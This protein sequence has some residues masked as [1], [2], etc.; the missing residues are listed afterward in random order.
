MPDF[1]I[2]AATDADRS[3]IAAIHA[4]S[5]QEQY[6]DVLPSDFLDRE[7]EGAME[8][9]WQDQ[10]FGEGD[11]V[12]M[13]EREGE[14]I[15]FAATWCGDCAYID[16]LHVRSGQRSGGVGRALLAET[17]RRLMTQGHSAADL[18]VVTSNDRA[19]KLYGALGGESAG[20]ENKPL[21]GHDVPH[22]RIRWADLTLL[23]A[24]AS[25]QT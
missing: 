16:N 22:E 12:L 8:R 17:A 10:P 9:H 11:V 4:A 21:L 7:I 14:A 24:F 18:H 20:F 25:D 15:G 3:V 5:W 23:S 2:R 6:R 13:A 19:R 1:T